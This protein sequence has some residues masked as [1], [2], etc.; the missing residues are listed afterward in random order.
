MKKKKLNYF[1]NYAIFL[2]NINNLGWQVL[3]LNLTPLDCNA[4]SLLVVL[5]D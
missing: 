4:A 5:I 1:I 3:H 2:Q